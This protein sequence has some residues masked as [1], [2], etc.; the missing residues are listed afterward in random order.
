LEVGGSYEYN[1]VRFPERSQRF[2]SHIGQ[3]RGLV[4]LNTSLSLTAFVQ[5]NSAQ[6]IVISNLRLRYNPH[7]GNDLYLVYDEGFNTNREREIPALPV[8]KN[9]TL[10]VKYTYTFVK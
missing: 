1:H 4:M 7:E 5:Y 9:R 2:T 10:L 3:F 6:D 8:M